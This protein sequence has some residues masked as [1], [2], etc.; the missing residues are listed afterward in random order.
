[1]DS[2]LLYFEAYNSLC[3][4]LA[5]SPKVLGHQYQYRFRR[6]N[7]NRITIGSNTKTTDERRSSISSSS[8]SHLPSL[9][10]SSQETYQTTIPNFVAL[11][12]YKPHLLVTASLININYQLNTML[13][14]YSSITSGKRL[15]PQLSIE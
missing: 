7:R 14:T 9:R 5:Q 10:N 3:L 11:R 4:K 13:S 2:T 12:K 15:T 1:M 8:N 6:P